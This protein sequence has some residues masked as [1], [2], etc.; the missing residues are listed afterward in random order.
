MKYKL[1]LEHKSSNNHIIKSW[2]NN[3]N[4]NLKNDRRLYDFGDE[5]LY[6]CPLPTIRHV[7]KYTKYDIKNY[8]QGGKPIIINIEI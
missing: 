3:I 8:L 2:F 6:G 7:I 1:Y 4:T 5:P